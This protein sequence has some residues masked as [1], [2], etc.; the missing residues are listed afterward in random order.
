[1]H[2]QVPEYFLHVQDFVD[3]Y[4]GPFASPDLAFSHYV[5]TR[6]V[7]GDSAAFMSISSEAPPADAMLVMTPEE[8]RKGAGNESS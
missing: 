2:H 5:W 7:R 4:I 8:D 1:M 3:A 6:D